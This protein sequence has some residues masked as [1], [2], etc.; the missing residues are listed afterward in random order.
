[1]NNLSGATQIF[2]QDIYKDSSVQQHVLGELGVTPDGRRFRY[3]KVGATA[4]VAGKLYQA[5]AYTTTHQ[6]MTCS[7]QAVGDKTITVSLGAS[8]VTANQYAGGYLNLNAGTGVGYCY[9]IASHPAADLSTSLVVTL[10]TPI[11]AATAVADT[12]GSLVPH[13]YNGVI[14]HPNTPTNVMAGVAVFTATAAYYCWLQ[15]GGPCAL[16]NDSATA[17]GLGLAPSASVT[18]AAKTAATTLVN[19]GYCME[20]GVNTEY[21]SVFL[22]IS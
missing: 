17:V 2:A 19:V 11:L 4:L 16:L 21:R 5:P 1:M 18:G 12:K 22:T 10:E 3:C 6:N 14:V 7:T 15:V 13:P 8:A 9:R 20:A